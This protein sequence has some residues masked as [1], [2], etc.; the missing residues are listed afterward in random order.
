MMSGVKWLKR[1]SQRPSISAVLAFVHFSET[2]HPLTLTFHMQV[3]NDEW[4]QM[5][6]APESAFLE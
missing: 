5:A 4:V 3:W 6:E 1:Q 2:I